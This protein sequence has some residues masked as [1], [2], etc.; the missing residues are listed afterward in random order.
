MHSTYIQP[1]VNILPINQVCSASCWNEGERRSE[2]VENLDCFNFAWYVACVDAANSNRERERV[3]GRRFHQ[4]T[5]GED[6]GRTLVSTKRPRRDSERVRQRDGLLERAHGHNDERAASIRAVDL[7]ACFVAVQK[8]CRLQSSRKQLKYARD[9]KQIIIIINTQEASSSWLDC[10]SVLP[11]TAGHKQSRSPQAA[12]E[13]SKSP[14]KTGAHG[15]ERPQNPQSKRARCKEGQRPKGI[16]KGIK[17]YPNTKHTHTHTQ[18]PLAALSPV[19]YW[20]Q[21]SPLVSRGVIR[22]AEVTQ[23]GFT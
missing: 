17:Y 22:T 15:Q 19:Q 12:L 8:Y 5:T 23:K 13:I 9:G 2:H 3:H 10:Q 18:T 20:T 6:T 7:F 16:K 11:H 4:N 14:R 21:V 1:V